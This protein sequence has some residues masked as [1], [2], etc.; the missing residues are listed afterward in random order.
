MTVKQILIKGWTLG[1][2]ANVLCVSTTSLRK[3][4][5]AG[6]LEMKQ[7]ASGLREK[8]N[9]SANKRIARIALA[10]GTTQIDISEYFGVPKYRIGK[11]IA[12]TIGIDK[13]VS[14][15]ESGKIN[16]PP[17]GKP[18]KRHRGGGKTP[19]YN[20]ITDFTESNQFIYS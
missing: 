16:P 14:M 12:D 8:T 10:F 15:L 13:L 1:E 3:Q 20:P 4:L 18:R 2:A 11:H 9:L 19:S 7:K 17:K 5:E 6:D